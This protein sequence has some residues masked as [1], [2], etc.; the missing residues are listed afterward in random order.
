MAHIN[1]RVEIYSA[2]PDE[3]FD[4][5]SRLRGIKSDPPE[6]LNPVLN[7]VQEQ[8]AP[9]TQ[10][11]SVEQPAAEASKRTRRT[12]AEMEADAR[13]AQ[14][15]EPVKTDLVGDTFSKQIHEAN[16]ASAAA[17]ATPVEEDDPGDVVTLDVLQQAFAKATAAGGKLSM[18]DAQ[19]LLKSNFTTAAG[20]P[21]RRIAEIQ[22]KDYA[23]V[24]QRLGG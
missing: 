15:A 6:V 9:D 22:P 5:M 23:A 17:K 14:P 13:A 2:D 3:V 10:V 8:P 1:F 21:V 24:L 20:E 12:K 18:Q 4:I 11:Q 7:P 16:A 19:N